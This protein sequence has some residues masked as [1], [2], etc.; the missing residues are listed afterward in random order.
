VIREAIQLLWHTSVT[1]TPTLHS[2]PTTRTTRR[3]RAIRDVATH[4]RRRP[5]SF[6]KLSLRGDHGR[7]SRDGVETRVPEPATMR[8][9]DQDGAGCP[10]DRFDAPT[11][12]STPPRRDLAAAGACT[13]G[14]RGM[15]G[16]VELPVFAGS[17]EWWVCC[18]ASA[19]AGHGCVPQQLDGFADHAITS[20]GPGQRRPSAWSSTHGL[21]SRR[22]RRTSQ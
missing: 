19:V 5:P 21:H 6:S 16:H 3:R 4:P 20:R 10:S 1:A 2:R 17:F 11:G 14:R 8:R 15:R 12:L 7:L 18:G 9:E 22:T 13:V